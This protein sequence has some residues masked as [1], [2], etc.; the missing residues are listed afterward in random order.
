[1]PRGFLA[2]LLIAGTAL[3][4]AAEDP[5]AEYAAR[6][7]KLGEKKDPK[8]WLALADFC[9]E[10]LLWGKREEALRKVVS[11]SPDNAEAHARLDE[12]KFG[13]GWLPVEE[14]EAKEAEKNQAKGL[15]F[16]GAKW[17]SP[18]EADKLREADRKAVGWNVEVRIDTPHFR[19]YSAR[20][21][22]FSRGLAGLLE[23]E[24]LAY[25]RFYGKVWKLEPNPAP[26]KAY[27]FADRETFVSVLK[28][29]LWHIFEG[30]RK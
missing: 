27:V 4:V 18:K 16:Y 24:V 19:V 10:H 17:V 23:N 5:G 2:A 15:V 9:E 8:G 13:K 22:D 11:L 28:T 30:M 25:Q 20:P 1:M 14:A 3:C 12:V 7:G 26:F 29:G 6:A 21:L